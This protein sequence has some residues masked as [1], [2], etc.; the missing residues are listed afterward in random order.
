MTRIFSNSSSKIW[1]SDN[2]GLKFKNFL[3]F[4]RN[5]ATRQI[6]GCWF[7]IWQWFFKIAAQHTKIRQ[8]LVPNLR[9]LSFAR[10]VLITQFGGRLLEIWQYFFNILAKNPKQS[11]FRS[12]FVFVFILMKPYKFTNLS[13]LIK[14]LISPKF[15]SFFCFWIKFYMLT[16]S[17]MLISR[18]ALV[19]WN[20]S[21]KHTMKII[22]V[23]S[24]KILILGNIWLE[25]NLGCWCKKTTVQ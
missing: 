23:I 11:I 18:S 3:C 16:N 9:I 6:R 17:R 25:K 13:V 21:P 22:L 15:K 12:N 7:Q 5:F 1:K 8:F 10:N 4:A 2:F 20:S 24:L 14:N 19:F